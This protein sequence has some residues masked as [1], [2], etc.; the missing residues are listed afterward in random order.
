ME[1]TNKKEMDKEIKEQAAE[2]LK[3]DQGS[4]LT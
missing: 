3:T 1:E 2:A 4:G